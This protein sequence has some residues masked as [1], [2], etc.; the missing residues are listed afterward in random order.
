MSRNHYLRLVGLFGNPATC[1]PDDRASIFRIKAE[2]EVATFQ[3]L[4]GWHN[5]HRLHS[6]PEGKY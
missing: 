6:D 1:F 3:F 2:V 5:P 4:E